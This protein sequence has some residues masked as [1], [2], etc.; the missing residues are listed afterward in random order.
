MV[1]S[2]QPITN[3]LLNVV[4]AAEPISPLQA[5]LS[6]SEALAA[7]L[8]SS[9]AVKDSS[10]FFVSKVRF[11]L[12]SSCV[13]SSKTR[14]AES[15]LSEISFGAASA[16]SYKP[17]AA[18]SIA[19]TSP[20]IA[21]THFSMR[22]RISLSSFPFS[23]DPGTLKRMP[24]YRVQWPPHRVQCGVLHPVTRELQFTHQ[25]TLRSHFQLS[26]NPTSKI[27]STHEK[28]AYFDPDAIS[29]LAQATVEMRC[30]PW[31]HAAH[32]LPPTRQSLS[33]AHPSRAQHVVC[34]AEARLQV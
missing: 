1:E 30:A 5:S 31:R 26:E 28:G 9:F 6:N 12:M 15:S 29:T 10:F 32:D 3:Y 23:V 22:R 2:T 20:G 17:M 27:V 21:D 7:L 4:L 16:A 19:R 11:A 18:R 25:K 24:L 13:F 8:S 14:V 34:N 33:R